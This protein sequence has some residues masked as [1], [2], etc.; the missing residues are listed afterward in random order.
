MTRLC[1]VWHLKNERLLSPSKVK[2]LR[3]IAVLAD[4]YD[5]VSSILFV[6]DSWI[7]QVLRKTYKSLKELH[8]IAECA[9][10]L[11]ST[12][13]F[14]D[15]TKQL[16]LEGTG[17]DLREL[18]RNSIIPVA[19][20]ECLLTF[21]SSLADTMMEEV[22]EPFVWEVYEFLELR[23]PDKPH[24]SRNSQGRYAPG[25]H[26][27]NLLTI[28]QLN[29]RAHELTGADWVSCTLDVLFQRIN[30]LSGVDFNRGI[31]NEQR[32]CLA[33]GEDLGRRLREIKSMYERRVS[34][35]CLA[36]AKRGEGKML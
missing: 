31:V 17:D 12:I 23:Y 28:Y 22:L 30:N 24:G 32:Q 13:G 18:S 35:L 20:F 26:D 4:K 1:L 33:C 19:A 16:L 34:G 5:C 15:A 8:A 11:Q 2:D 10:L 6:G 29:L 14:K 7:Q 21:R 27:W 36:S 3:A 9:L 25:Q